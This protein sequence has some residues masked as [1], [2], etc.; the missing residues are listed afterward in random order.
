MKRTILL[1]LLILSIFC[2]AQESMIADI[3]ESVET[4]FGTYIPYLV[5]IE[6]D[7]AQYE[8]ESDFSNVVNFTDFN[9][10][11]AQKAKLM[12]NHFVVIPGRDS[13]P[14]GYKEIYDIYNEAREK[15]IPQ[16]ITT[17]AVLH[18]YHKLY[19]KILMTAEEEYFIQFLAKMDSILFNEALNQYNSATDSFIKGC[20][21]RLAAYF[22]V[23]LKILNEDFAIPDSVE[24]I[25]NAELA[26]I[27]AHEAY[28][29]SSLF[30][31]YDEDYSQYKPR[32]HYTK[33]DSLEKYF[34]AMMWHGRQTFTLF[35]AWYYGSAP[36]PDL[37]GAAL[38]LIHL[39][40][41]IQPKG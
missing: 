3:T 7:A 8:I 27:E 24:D 13:G 39:M 20:F 10:T 15:D 1:M 16:F 21:K 28:A 18:T 25:V 14:T 37:T 23:P 41:N 34:K 17:D 32:G 35:D 11:E 26:L 12:Q 19:D 4:E 9:F 22:S 36:R 30:D 38:A 6:P 31:A 2:Y 5:E 29:L 33:T 40:E